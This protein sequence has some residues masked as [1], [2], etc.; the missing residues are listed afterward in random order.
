MNTKKTDSVIVYNH[1][2]K[3][4]FLKRDVKAD[5]YLPA[6]LSNIQSMSLLLINDGQDLVTMKFDEIMENLYGEEEITPLFCVG[7]HCSTDRKNEY[8]TAKS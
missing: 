4:K 8:G 7:I 1:V 6:Q 5:C 2:L 3:S